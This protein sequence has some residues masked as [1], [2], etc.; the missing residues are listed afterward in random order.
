MR[1][2][3]SIVTLACVLLAVHPCVALNNG[4]GIKPAMG[5]NTWNAFNVNSAPCCC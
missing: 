3:C 2:A 1:P 4:L 5:F